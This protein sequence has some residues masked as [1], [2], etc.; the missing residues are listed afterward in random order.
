M[1]SLTFPDGSVREYAP[2]TSGR[3][4]A[5]SIAKSLEKSGYGAY[6]FNILKK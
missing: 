1:I 5:G 4:V 3:E 2:G 6:L